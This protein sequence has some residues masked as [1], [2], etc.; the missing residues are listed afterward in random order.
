MGMEATDI[1]RA[2]KGRAI[3][4]VAADRNI[5]AYEMAHITLTLDNGEIYSLLPQ[6]GLG[7]GVSVVCEKEEPQVQVGLNDARLALFI[8]LDLLV[9]KY[10]SRMRR[11]VIQQHP[12]EWARKDRFYFDRSDGFA[13]LDIA[14]NCHCTKGDYFNIWLGYVPWPDRDNQDY[15]LAHYHAV[16]HKVEAE[17][18]L[19]GNGTI[20]TSVY[21][22]V[23]ASF[24]LRAFKA[25]CGLQIYGEHC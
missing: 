25:A 8:D 20:H 5:Y 9:E 1:R 17:D 6:K 18:H 22:L 2:L 24:V 16:L 19:L 23:D 14:Q 15:S 10:G 13:V 4:D 12:E 7:N 11:V 21:G 3:V